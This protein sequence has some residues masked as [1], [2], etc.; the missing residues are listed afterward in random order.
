MHAIVKADRM[1]G[2]ASL[3]NARFKFTTVKGYI[4]ATLSKCNVLCLS[5]HALGIVHCG[6]RGK[7]S[8]Y[9]STWALHCDTQMTRKLTD[10]HRSSR[11]PELASL[12]GRPVLA[13]LLAVLSR[14]GNLCVRYPWRL[15]E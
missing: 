3:E 13:A 4:L 14:S 5:P 11:D 10:R 9:L 1:A 6:P 8:G 12:R 2:Q 15:V 7:T